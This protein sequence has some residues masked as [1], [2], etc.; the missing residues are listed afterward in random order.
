M[1]LAFRGAV[2]EVG[3]MEGFDELQMQYAGSAFVP[4][5]YKDRIYGIP[6]TQEFYV[7]YIRTDIFDEL[8]LEIPNTWQELMALLPVLQANSLSIGLPYADGYATMNN[9]IGTINLFPT[10]LAQHGIDVYRDSEDMV[11]SNLM[12]PRRPMMRLSNGSTSM[13]SMTSACIRM[14]LIDSEQEKCRW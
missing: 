3:S 10:L 14:I 1:N 13:C 6:E 5:E 7:M 2:A 12:I 4:Y 9:G 11:V 8:N